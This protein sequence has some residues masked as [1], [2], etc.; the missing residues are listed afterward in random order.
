MPDP[1]ATQSGNVVRVE[2]GGREIFFVGTAHVSRQS[3]EEVRSVIRGLRPDSV[4]VEL[5]PARL[6]SLEDDSRWRRLDVTEILRRD[7]AGIFLASLL[8]AGFQKRLGDRLGVRP[9]AEMLA[10]VEEARAIGA[11]VVLADRDVQATL[12]RSAAALGVVDRAKVAL[13]LAALPFAATDIDPEEVERLK[14]REA[15]G[16]VMETFAREMPAL[17][18]PLIDERDHY[19]VANVREAPGPRIVA[20]VGAAHVAG[21]VAHLDEAVDREALARAPALPLA[22]RALRLLPP[23]GLAA[24]VGL[25]VLRGHAVLH[26]VAAP[27]ILSTTLLA[28]SLASVASGSLAGGAAAGLL[29]PF[30]LA[31]PGFRLGRAAGLVMTRLAPPR[32]DDGPALRDDVLAPSRARQNTLLRCLLVA[33]AGSLGGGL[34]A[35]IALAWALVRI[36]RGG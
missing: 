10:A 14:S 6:E 25:S 13:L 4:C 22:T 33:V 27:W 20:V 11:R 15:I 21:M 12:S 24:L 19:L 9:G 18:T 26:A 29:A 28:G 7:R 23:V 8:F 1:A 30:A 5:D 32:P 17:K 16:D 31:V 35:V 36:L 34:G 2:H 3:V